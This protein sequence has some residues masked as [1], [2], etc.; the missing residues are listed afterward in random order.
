MCVQDA[1]GVVEA[2]RFHVFCDE[3]GAF[4]CYGSGDLVYDSSEC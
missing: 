1:R 2:H 4:V 3:E